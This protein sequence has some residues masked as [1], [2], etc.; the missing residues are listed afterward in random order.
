MNLHMTRE[1]G[2]EGGGRRVRTKKKSSH[3]HQR[4][5]DSNH[6]I[7]PIESL[8]VPDSFDHWRYMLKVVHLQQTCGKL[9]RE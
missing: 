6:L 3:V 8:R 1:R 7:L 5:A 4:F 9:W 2:D